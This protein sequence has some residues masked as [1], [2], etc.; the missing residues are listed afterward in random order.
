MTEQKI[1]ALMIGHLQTATSGLDGISL[2]FIGAWQPV[3]G[4][5]ALETGNVDGVVA[6]KCMPRTYETPTIPD[7]SF[8]II[9]S[10]S[11][12]A[13][14]DSGGHDYLDVTDA[15]STCLHT[16]QK[17]FE[18]YAQAFAVSGEFSPTGYNIESGDCGLDADRAVWTYSATVNL[19]GIIT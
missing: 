8:Q 11:V 6:V 3:S 9:V 18:A 19:Y 1:E 17:S 5:K 16:W 2:Q 7:G 10:L 15:I 12:R 4:V 14:A 13:D